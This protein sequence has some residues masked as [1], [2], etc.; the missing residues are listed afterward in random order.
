MC[1]L[2]TYSALRLNLNVMISKEQLQHN[3]Y[4]IR[5]LTIP[6]NSTV[7]NFCGFS[8]S[9][10]KK[11]CI[12]VTCLIAFITLQIILILSDFNSSPFCATCKW[13][14]GCTMNNNKFSTCIMCKCHPILQV[15]TKI[16]HACTV[17]TVQHTCR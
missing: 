8:R 5:D 3:T 11:G 6:Y 17:H 12:V 15:A 7:S 4:M 2:A 13:C 9:T 10:Y 16:L 14:R 1:F